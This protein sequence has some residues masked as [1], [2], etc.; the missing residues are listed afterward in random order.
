VP[1]SLIVPGG[2]PDAPAPEPAVSGP[3][4]C[5]T[6]MVVYILPDGRTMV[7][8]DLDVPLQPQRKPSGDELYS[9][10]AIVLKDV[11][12]ASAATMTADRVVALQEHRMREAIE[13]QQQMQLQQALGQAGGR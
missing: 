6:A 2:R 12:N 8:D 3:I 5:V 13:R 10:A 7:S 1:S 9:M 4:P 11:H